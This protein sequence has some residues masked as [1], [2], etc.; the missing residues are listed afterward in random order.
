MNSLAFWKS[1]SEQNGIRCGHFVHNLEIFKLLKI[2]YIQWWF[3]GW[4]G[5]LEVATPPYAEVRP[6]NTPPPPNGR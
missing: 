4:L 1:G 3:F 2:P 5:G 6:P